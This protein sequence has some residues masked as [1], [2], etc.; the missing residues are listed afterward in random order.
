[1]CA[2]GAKICQAQNSQTTCAE[3]FRHSKNGDAF[4]ERIMTGDES[5]VHHCDPL[6]KIQSMEWHHELLQCKKKFK[7]QNSVVKVVAKVFWDSEGTFLV[8]FFE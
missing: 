3:L 5:W 6:P 2:V 4:L 1:M 7:V 8:E